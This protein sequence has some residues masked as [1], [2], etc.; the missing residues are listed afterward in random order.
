MNRQ[1]SSNN[2]SSGA[3]RT[4]STISPSHT[5]NK[6][7]NQTFETEVPS[8]RVVLHLQRTIGNHAV[9]KLMQRQAP[10]AKDSVQRLVISA[11]RLLSIAGEPKKDITLSL[12]L[13]SDKTLRR[14]SENYKSILDKI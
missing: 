12:P 5:V 14:M 3:K 9:T 8:E 13:F 2:K 1:Q 11:P 4:P 6:S 7:S 10:A